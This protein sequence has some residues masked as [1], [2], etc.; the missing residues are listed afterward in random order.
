MSEMRQSFEAERREFERQ[1]EVSK[2]DMTQAERKL[3]NEAQQAAAD[4]SDKVSVA[5]VTYA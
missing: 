4:Y 2:T 1:M 5:M 3:R